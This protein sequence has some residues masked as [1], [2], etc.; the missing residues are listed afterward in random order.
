MTPAQFNAT[1]AHCRK[2]IEE[3]E[4]GKAKCPAEGLEWARRFLAN[5]PR[6]IHAVFD[7]ET[8][9]TPQHGVTT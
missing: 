7:D 2:L 1:R 3:H 9:V 8:A 5:N 4:S 6:D